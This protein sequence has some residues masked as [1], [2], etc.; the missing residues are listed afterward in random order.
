MTVPTPTRRAA[1]AA[2]AAAAILSPVAKAAAAKDRPDG[3]NA[4]ATAKGMRFG[5]A[6]NWS[7]QDADRGSFANPAYARLLRR[8]CGVLVPENELKWQFIRPGPDRFDFTHFDAMIDW[9]D[10]ENLPVR[11]HNLLW[12]RTKWLPKW[13]N[14]HDFGAHP[15]AE[16]ERLLVAHIQTVTRRYGKRIRSYDVVNETVND[17][18][19]TLEQ[20]VFSRAM[21]STEAVIDLA[22]HT[23]RAEAPHAQ[24][25]YND[26]MS[27]EPGMEAHCAGVLRLLEGMKKR[28]TP[29]DA[30]GVQ[31]HIIT[32]G[33]DKRGGMLAMQAHWRRFLD[34]VTGLG[35]KLLITEFDV[36]DNGL[37][38]ATAPRDQAVADYTRAYLDVMF[39]YPQLS[40]VLAWG[41]C[42][43]YSWIEGFEPRSDGA[44]RR[45]CPYD[46]RFVAKPMYAAIAEA[47]KHAPHR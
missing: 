20:T 3:L 41:M 19:G 22:F 5:S 9:A 18:D 21:G 1:I 34:D 17:K 39:A 11:G 8:D 38:A 43:R 40:D 25:V 28:G 16:A 13:V 7:A 45:P 10:R 33:T 31:S 14:D 36:R 24:L 23:A 37:P 26:Y 15:A 32:Q 47:F 35:L 29:V 46:D 42:D 12:H 2:G 30:L 4:G 44:R 27:W 6:Y